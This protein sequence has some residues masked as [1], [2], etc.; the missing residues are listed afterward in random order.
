M[1]ANDGNH[2]DNE[3][4]AASRDHADMF[5]GGSTSRDMA[6]PSSLGGLSAKLNRFSTKLAGI[7]L[8][9]GLVSALSMFFAFEASRDDFE[10]AAAKTVINNATLINE[11]VERNLF[12]RYGD[13][14]AFGLNVAAHDPAN[15]RR[16]SDDNPL[17]SSMN[18]YMTGYG[19]YN[20]MMLVD[21]N[22]YL[23]AV[24]TVDGTGN[25]VDTRPLYDQSFANEAWFKDAISGNFLAGTNG[26]TGTAVQ[27]VYRDATVAGIVGAK[28]DFVIP[29]SAQVHD[30]NGKLIGVWVNFASFGLVEDIFKQ[31]YDQMAADGLSHAE[32]TLLDKNGVVLVDYDP[33][34]QGWTDYPRNFDVIGKLNLVEKNVGAAMAAVQGETG[35]MNATHARKKIDQVSGYAHTTGGYDYVGLGW[36]TLVRATEDEAY[37][38]LTSVENFMYIVIAIAALVILVSGFGIGTLFARPIQGLTDV[39]SR[40]ANGDKMADVPFRSRGDEIGDLARAVQVFKENSLKMEE[41]QKEQAEADRKA[42]EAQS[43]REAEDR[44]RDAKAEEERHAHEASAA[45]ERKQAMLDMADAF[46]RS[47]KGVVEQV[48]SAAA[49]L[50]STAEAMTANAEETTRQTSNAAAGT[51]QAAANVQTVATASEELTSSISEISRQVAESATIAQSAVEEAER[52]TSSMR[53]LAEASQKIGDVIS[54]INDIAGQTNL[55]ALNATIEAARAGEAGKGFAVVASEVKNLATQTAKATDE[56]T[57]QIG[58]IQDASAGSVE[59]IDGISTT[60]GKINEISNSI[61]SAVEQQNAATGEIS[62]SVQEAAAGTQE[63]T[64]NIGAITQRSEETG[65]AASQVLSA[66]NEL[67]Q[68]SSQLSLEVDKFLTDVRGG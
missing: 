50:Q 60:I 57:Q 38:A 24:N 17:V 34:A 48:G 52:T 46:E 47:V 39:T 18:G 29:Y 30:S 19:L 68:H 53:G 10:D 65:A 11:I 7:L 20:L 27:D 54:L 63:V 66:A 23:L 32:L 28:N 13:V 40:L 41:M 33:A 42:A 64:E 12:E 4:A 21:P 6:M 51:R 9:F 61:A 35:A 22:G 49:E 14:Q 45:E 44:E 25:K 58:Q 8:A 5:S 3:Y 31:F 43:A 55:L 62:R 59:A 56:I 15:F 26:L 67:S 36:S 16:P 1:T 2:Q 37:L